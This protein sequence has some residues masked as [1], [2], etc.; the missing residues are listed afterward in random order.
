MAVVK[1][2]P[3]VAPLAVLKAQLGAAMFEY[4]LLLSGI[5]LVAILGV[6]SLGDIAQDPFVALTN[7]S[8]DPPTTDSAPPLVGAGPVG[9]SSGGDNLDDDPLDGGALVEGALEGGTL[10][11]GIS[12]VDTLGSGAG[13]ASAGSIRGDEGAVSS[14][15]PVLSAASVSASNNSAVSGSAVGTGSG[16]GKG[17]SGDR[18]DGGAS[19]SSAEYLATQAQESLSADTD[20]STASQVAATASAAATVAPSQNGQDDAIERV[21]PAADSDVK[22][23]GKAAKSRS[24]WGVALVLLEIALL[25]YLLWRLHLFIQRRGARMQKVQQRRWSGI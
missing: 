6:A 22:T 17:S 14:V 12:G 18:G 5:A 11:G 25:G 10:D 9:G 2:K 19:A 4:A 8:A 3:A 23:A 1:R 15:A 21:S 7:P 24:W 13:G 16:Y 20:S